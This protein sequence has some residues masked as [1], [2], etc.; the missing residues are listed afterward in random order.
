MEQLND[1][2]AELEEKMRKSAKDLLSDYLEEA[3]D[4]VDEIKE[5]VKKGDERK[6]FLRQ[7][8]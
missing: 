7:D 1:Q 8:V 4:L 3:E 2:K 6:R 5:Q